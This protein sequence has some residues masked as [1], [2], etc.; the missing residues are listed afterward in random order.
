MVKSEPASKP[1]KSKTKKKTTKAK[2]KSSKPK[3]K[4]TRSVAPKKPKESNYDYLLKKLDD[5]E[6]Q[7]SHLE[8]RL[9]P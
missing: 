7:I 2:T 3:I 4:S 6:N 9:N 5:L 1:K 8:G